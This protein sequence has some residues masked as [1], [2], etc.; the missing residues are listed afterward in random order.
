MKN[1]AKDFLQKAFDEYQTKTIVFRGKCHDCQKPVKIEAEAE[2]DGKLEI[3]GGAL[4]PIFHEAR[5]C[6]LFFKCEECFDRKPILADY[7][8]TEVFSRVVGYLRPIK[9]WNPGKASEFRDRKVFDLEI[10]SEI[11]A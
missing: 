2:L 6:E 5:D 8:E 3:R 7:Q 4:Y 9:Q 10:N 11:D 1:E